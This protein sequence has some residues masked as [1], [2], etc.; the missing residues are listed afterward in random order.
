MIESQ[1]ILSCVFDLT[2][3]PGDVSQEIILS[4]LNLIVLIY[5][6]QFIIKTYRDIFDIVQDTL[7]R[8]GWKNM[9]ND[10]DFQRKKKCKI[11]KMEP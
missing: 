8:K 11:T 9:E 4:P 3:Q 10:V 5:L 2:Q 7:E 1:E 6:I